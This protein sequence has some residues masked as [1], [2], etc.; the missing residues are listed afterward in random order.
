MLTMLRAAMLM[1]GMA[2]AQTEPQAPT[3]PPAQ[4]QT[5]SQPPAH[6][7]PSFDCNRAARV[8][9]KRFM[10]SSSVVDPTAGSPTSMRRP[11]PSSCLRRR[12]SRAD[13][14][15]WLASVTIAAISSTGN[16]PTYVDVYACLRDELNRREGLLRVVVASKQFTKP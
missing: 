15:V 9:V 2:F 16:P 10:D 1:T 11:R 4:T 8:V 12:N 7:A 5:P 13:Q 6:A 14:R 3:E